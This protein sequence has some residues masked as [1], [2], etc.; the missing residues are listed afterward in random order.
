MKMLL[1]K[2]W[3]ESRMR[4][5]AGM[6][7]CVIVCAYYASSHGWL[8]TMWSQELVKDPKAL[9]HYPWMPLGIHEYGWYVWHYLFDN[10]LQ[11]V[12]ALFAA[13]FAFGGL[14]R[15][16]KSGTSLFS[17]GLPVSRRQWL[18]SRLLVATAESALL[19][20]F[21]V[22]VVF[23]SSLGIHES[24]SLA[25]VLAHAVLMVAG[26]VFFVALGNLCSSL[27][28]G[29]YLALILMLV[30]FGIPY[31]LV[32]NLEQSIRAAGGAAWVRDL[33]I[34]HVMA[35]PWQL[36]WATTPWAGVGMIWLVTAALVGVAV[37]H[38]DRVDY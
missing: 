11:Q 18:L 2:A 4:F 36:R 26:G 35:G 8:V 22:L 6:A 3:I 32:Q 10:Y 37:K 7:A 25:Q 19:G 23:V 14:A 24:Y 33:D 38:G 1:Y 12:W 17:L 21:G 15:E 30:V 16:K 29:E 27:F 28:P 5:V 31:L 13:L 20:L 9:E 34:A